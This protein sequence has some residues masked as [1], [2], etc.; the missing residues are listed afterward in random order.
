MND[1]KEAMSAV[2]EMV[3]ASADSKISDEQS[4]NLLTEAVH[5]AEIAFGNDATLVLKE[6]VE[7]IADS[8]ESPDPE[9]KNRLSGH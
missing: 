1:V 3:L 7:D 9:C 5:N 4:S 8:N 2:Y 6:I